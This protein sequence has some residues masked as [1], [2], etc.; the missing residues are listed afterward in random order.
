MKSINQFCFQG[1][2]DVVAKVVR[3]DEVTSKIYIW[4]G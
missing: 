1:F 4:D 3:K 2:C